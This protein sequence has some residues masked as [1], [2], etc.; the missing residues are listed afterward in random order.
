VSKEK[1]CSKVSNRGKCDRLSKSNAGSNIVLT[2][3][4]TIEWTACAQARGK[5]KCYSY[6]V[7]CDAIIV[8]ITIKT[9]IATAITRTLICKPRDYS[10]FIA[11]NCPCVAH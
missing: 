1:V 9:I 5:R 4:S 7:R 8:Q 2:I 3:K 10:D 11:F 6:S